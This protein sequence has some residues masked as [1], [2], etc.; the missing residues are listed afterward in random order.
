MRARR[1]LIAP[2]K[3]TPRREIISHQLMLLRF[4]SANWPPAFYTWLP[5]GPA[6][7]CVKVERIV[8]PKKWN[9][10]GRART[11]DAAYSQA[12]LWAGNL[13]LDEYGG[14]LLRMND[15]ATAASFGFGPTHEEYTDLIRTSEQAI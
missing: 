2:Q 12:E 7:P 11:A 4:D 13:A 3:E 15:G 1:Y 8:R 10:S 14:E 5:M 6:V 9:R